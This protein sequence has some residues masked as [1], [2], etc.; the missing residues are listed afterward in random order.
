RVVI[1]LPIDGDIIKSINKDND[2]FKQLDELIPPESISLQLFHNGH[3]SYYIN[4]NFAISDFSLEKEGS[5]WILVGG[6]FS[7][8]IKYNKIMLKSSI[9]LKNV[10]I[11]WKNFSL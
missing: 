3:S 9:P 5:V 11:G 6:S 8:K 10:H 1:Q 7:S 4:R 2:I